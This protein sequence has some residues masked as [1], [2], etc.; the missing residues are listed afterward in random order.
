MIKQKEMKKILYISLWLF[1][2]N[3]W[4]QTPAELFKQGNDAYKK[5]EYQTAI[6]KYEKVLQAGKQSEE[7]YFNLGNAYYKLNQIAPSIYYYEK[8]LQLNPGDEDV[9]YNLSLA[10]QM[11]LD[12]ID[13]VPENLLLRFKK[14][15][16]RLFPFDVWAWLAIISAFAGLIVFILF[17]FTSNGNTKRMSFV[18]M[19][20]SLFLLLFTWY[21]A[22]YG[23]QLASQRYGIIFA[24]Q[25]DILTE[26]NLTADKVTTLHEGTKVKLLRPEGD[27]QLIKLPDGKKAWIPK[28]EVKAL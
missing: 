18:A 6:G 15:I 13:Q 9:Q 20:I 8:A 17:L 28:T 2:L 19:F 4:S 16:N 27:W 24:D 25:V 1:G 26:P 11:K 3:L 10:N 22:H 12:K 7:L 14:K 23:K 21:N 5:G